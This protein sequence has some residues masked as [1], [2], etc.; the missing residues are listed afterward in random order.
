MHLLRTEISKELTSDTEST[1][2]TVEHESESF[3]V[4]ENR[5]I[6]TMTQ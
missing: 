6:T 4:E 3:L 5:K 1:A 2:R